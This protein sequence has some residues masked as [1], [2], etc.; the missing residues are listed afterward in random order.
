VDNEVL[1]QKSVKLKIGEFYTIKITEADAF[2][3]YGE[4]E[5]I[6]VK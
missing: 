2:D 1:I 5:K 4:I 6:S 3:L